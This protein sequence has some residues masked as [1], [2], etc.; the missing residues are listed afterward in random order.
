MVIVFLEKFGFMEVD[1]LCVILLFCVEVV[2]LVYNYILEVVILVLSLRI[3]YKILN[4]IGVLLL[5]I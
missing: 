3:N 2:E 5:K 1:L 4:D